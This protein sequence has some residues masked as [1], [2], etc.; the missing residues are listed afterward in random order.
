MAKTTGALLIG[1]LNYDVY[2]SV[3]NLNGAVE[4]TSLENTIPLLLPL[5]RRIG[6]GAAITAVAL[7]TLGLSTTV[8]GVVGN[9]SSQL[10]ETLWK[11]GVATDVVTHSDVPT[12][13]TRAYHSPDGKKLYKADIR[14]NQLFTAKD[15]TEMLDEV[16]RSRIVMRTGYPWTPEIAGVPTAELF[17]YA[18]KNCTITALDMS[19]PA[20]WPEGMLESLI[21]DVLPQ[22]DL[23]CANAWELYSLARRPDEPKLNAGEAEDCMSPKRV[24]ECS[25]RLIKGGVSVVNVHY[26]EKGT[27]LVTANGWAHALPPYV[28]Q[29]VNPTGCGNLQNAGI[30]YCMLN[31]RRPDRLGS[32]TSFG[33]D[34][35]YAA[36]FANAA[37][38]LR[39]GGK[40]FPS[41]KEIK[42]RA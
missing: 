31:D 26:G 29:T 6:G 33:L 19:S 9:D 17:R 39:L 35:P 1:A 24:L 23:L 13:V 2:I 10:L 12:A 8:A 15:L 25:A 11:A 37:A 34:L 21:S 18:R 27:V 20:K 5:E 32:S 16:G 4:A 7:A 28:A 38:A 42:A 14:S 3:P 30:I 22:V 41:F 40:E 36:K